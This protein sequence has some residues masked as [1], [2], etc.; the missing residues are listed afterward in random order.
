[1]RFLANENFPGAAVAAIAAAGH[2]IISIRLVAAGASDAAV[3][4]RGVREE[5]I[6]LTFDKDFGE[7][8]R[9]AGLPATC[10]IVLFR[11]PMPRP[12][13]VGN[14]LAQQL[15]SRDDWAGHFSVIE[16][17]RIRMRPLA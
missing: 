1:M 6:L 8:A 15:A 9:A 11:L 4:E 2:D 13:E 3:R 5:R 10:G 14:R 12:G 16:P 17:G 7:L